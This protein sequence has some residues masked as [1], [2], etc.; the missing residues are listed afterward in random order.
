MS[1]RKLPV[2]TE[3]AIGSVQAESASRGA[4][5]ERLV[6]R[7]KKVS[8]H[9]G[10]SNCC[11]LPIEINLMEAI[12]IY[13]EIVQK[14]RWTPAFVKSLQEHADKTTLLS[15][16]VWVLMGLPCPLLQDR[17]CTV[18]SVRPFHCRTMW[19]TGD[20]FYCDGPNWGSKTTLVPKDE[21]MKDYLGYVELLAKQ[22][23]IASYTF[24]VSRALL[25]AEKIVQGSIDPNDVIREIVKDL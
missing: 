7:D 14:G 2:L 23:G 25:I 5:F 11:Y 8:C 3:Q 6:R 20:P 18:Y 21:V 22:A 15:P 9:T 19:A 10:C 17:R 1:R 13:R 24:P 16:A 12:P 4:A